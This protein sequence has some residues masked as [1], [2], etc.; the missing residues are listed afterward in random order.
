MDPP[1][2]PASLQSHYL[3]NNHLAKVQQLPS[4]CQPSPFSKE[5]DIDQDEQIQLDKEAQLYKNEIMTASAMA[6]RMR[7]MTLQE[8]SAVCESIIAMPKTPYIR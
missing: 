4:L 3:L 7:K 8:D 2:I 6:A 5:I 1:E